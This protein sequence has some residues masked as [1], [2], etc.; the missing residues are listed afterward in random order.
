MKKRKRWK[1]NW[2]DSHRGDHKDNDNEKADY[3]FKR[4]LGETFSSFSVLASRRWFRPATLL[5]MVVIIVLIIVMII[6]LIIVLIIILSII[7]IIVMIKMLCD[8]YCDDNGN[9]RLNLSFTK[10][11]KCCH[12]HQDLASAPLNH[13][14]GVFRPSYPVAHHVPDNNNCHNQHYNRHDNCHNQHYNRHD[15]CHDNQ[16]YHNWV[17]NHHGHQQ[18]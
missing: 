8:D 13:R 7:L 3:C 10:L 6:I 18:S 15:D 4:D 17:C 12:I 9:E 5:W 16:Y 11:I 1:L 14:L 2:Q